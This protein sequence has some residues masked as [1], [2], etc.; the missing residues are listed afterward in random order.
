M[1]RILPAVVFAALG[2]AACN[3]STGSGP[4]LTKLTVEPSTYYL[5]VGDTV[6]LSAVGLPTDAKSADEAIAV[7]PKY[8]SSNPSVATVTSSGKVTAVAVGTATITAKTGGQVATATINVLAGSNFRTFNVEST[9]ETGCDNPQYHLSRLVASTAH[10]ELYE[11]TQNPSGGFT[12]AEYQAIANEFEAVSYQTDVAN[13][14]TPT[15]IDGN[16]K[17]IG[18]FTRAVNELTPVSANYV[19]GGFFYPRDL[20]RRTPQTGFI[21]CPTSNVAEIFYLLAVDSA[22]TINSHVR[23]K[24]YVRENTLSTLPHELQHLINAGR[25]FYVNHVTADETI[26]LDEGLS[27]VAEELAYYAKSGYAP[28]QN[29]N[30]TQTLG[31]QAQFN[32]FAEYQDNNLGRLSLYLQDPPGNSP[33]ANNDELETR[34]ATWWLLRYLADRKGGNQQAT[35]FALVNSDTSG[36]ANLQKVLGV[37]PMTWARDWAVTN[38]TDDAVATASQFQEPSW[39]HRSIFVNGTSA[40]TYPLRVNTLAPGITTTATVMSGSAAYYKFGVAPAATADVR[41]VQSGGTAPACTATTL[42]VGQV[43]QVTLNSGVGFCLAGGATGA[44]YVAIPFYGSS[45]S[46]NTIGIS[47]TAVGVIAP[48]GPPT[49]VRAAVANILFPLDGFDPQTMRGGGRELELRL[50]ARRIAA[51]LRQGYVAPEMRR[52]LSSVE[53]AAG[54]TINLVRTK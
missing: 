5:A 52:E 35:W 26:W 32:N 20:Y 7:K 38:Y 50:R 49:P 48:V 51:R 42:A 2:L 17:V 39:N 34:G 31:T 10:V 54:V 43:Q 41:F 25:R 4:R 30:A 18:V 6:T 28:G 36:I 44:E 14:G 1:K 40:H 37:D 13:F 47:I 23:S 19:F 27:H 16:G 12:N 9:S 15:D 8:E 53:G 3:D 24:A 22:G 21:A 45:T 29:L 11:D 33:I 46:S